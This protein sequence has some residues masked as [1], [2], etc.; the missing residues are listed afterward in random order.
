MILDFK[1][2]CEMHEN[3]K[4]KKTPFEWA[5]EICQGIKS[6]GQGGSKPNKKVKIKGAE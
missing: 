6:S 4:K 5:R 3:S 2:V 1:G